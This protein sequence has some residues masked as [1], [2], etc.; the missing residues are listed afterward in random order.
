MREYMSYAAEIGIC[1]NC[2][3]VSHWV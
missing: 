1:S 2:G 3:V